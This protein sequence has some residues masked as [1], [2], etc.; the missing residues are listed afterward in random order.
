MM[1]RKDIPEEEMQRRIDVY[2]ENKGIKC[3]MCNDTGRASERRVERIPRFARQKGHGKS[4]EAAEGN[5]EEIQ[6]LRWWSVPCPQ[7]SRDS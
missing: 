4:R 2:Y 3:R 5:G 6:V 7:C 1:P